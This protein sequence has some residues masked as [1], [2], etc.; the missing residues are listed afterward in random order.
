LIPHAQGGILVEC[1][2]GSTLPALLAGLAAFGLQP[3]Q[4]SDVLL[5]HIHLDHAGSAGWWAE[6]G[7]R[8]HV[9][10]AGAPHLLNPHK[11]ISSA[12]RIYGE[13][14]QSLW[15]DFLPVPED[16][17]VVHR[18]I[19]SPQD[20]ETFTLAGLPLRALDLPG[21]ASHHLAYICQGVCFTGDVGGIRVGGARHLRLPLPPPEI[22][23][24]VWKSSV[25]RLQAGQ[26]QGDFSWIAPT[27]FGLYPDPAWH[28]QALYQA[29]E[30]VEAWIEQVMPADPPVE[31]L[32]RL[33]LEWTRQQ[34][35]AAS[36]PAETDRQFELANPSWM[37]ARGI[38]RYWHKVLHPTRPVGF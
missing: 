32:N 36:L 18:R 7:A 3:G 8:I 34:S 31:E 4:I 33:F 12:S 15:G 22:D 21:H 30:D 23:L 9:H 38:Y 26:R 6:Q 16:R 5:T 19:G 20:D 35:Q 24:A 25:R 29:L 14:M 17:L 10:P 11:L 28:L 13:A 1:G 37:A 27:H 2:P